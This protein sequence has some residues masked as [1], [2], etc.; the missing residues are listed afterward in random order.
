MMSNSETNAGSSGE[1]AQP[2]PKWRPLSPRQRRVLGVLVEKAKTT[3]DA[4]P[5]SVN[6]IVAGC[7][8]KSNRSPIMNLSPE[9]VEDVLGELRQFGVVAEV[10]QGGRV[11][12]YRHY[13][14]D[15]LGVDKFELAVTTEL[16][17][18]GEQTVG[19]LRGRASRMEPIA[20]LQTLRPILQSLEKKNLLLSLTPEGRGQIVSHNLYKDRE[21]PELRQRYAAGSAGAET[22]ASERE[23][24][25][26]SRPELTSAPPPRG[27]VTTD[28]F[29][30]LQLEVAELRAEVARLRERLSAME[31][32]RNSEESQP[33]GLPE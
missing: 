25:I 28:M 3:P 21:I 10:Q 30:E 6:A 18:R 4:Y 29:V 20:D 7:N 5:M 23:P 12:R 31:G 14:H 8:Q 24:S 9:D 15:W 1:S 33:G 16:L 26:E 2:T 19:E 32:G 27:G 17:L 11:P 13:M 22:T